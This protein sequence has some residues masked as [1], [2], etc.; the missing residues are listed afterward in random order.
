MRKSLGTLIAI[1]LILALLPSIPKALAV[2]DFRVLASPSS[3]TTTPG[4]VV[5]YLVE[6]DLL[7]PPSKEVQLLVSPWTLELE[8]FTFTWS[9]SSGFP[10]FSAILRVAVS[11]LKPPGTYTIPISGHNPE[12]GFRGKSVKL[13]VL[14]AVP[15]TDWE[16]SNPT[17]TPSAPKVG[18]SVTFKV[19]LRALGT[20][21]PYPQAVKIVAILD[22]TAISGGTIN[23]PGPTGL[24]MT[25]SSTPPW[26]AK[27]GAHTITWIVDPSP[28]GYD[29]P[30]RFN[31]EVSLPFTVE[32]II[33][34][35]DF[36]LSVIP[37]SRTIKAGESTTYSVEVSLEEG[38]AQPV[39]LSLSGFPSGVTYSFDPAESVPTF[40][41]T[42]EIGTLSNTPVGTY[43]LV[44]SAS[45][46]GK[47][48]KAEITLIVTSPIE[49]DFKI[50]VNPSTQTITPSQ[51]ITYFVDIEPIGGFDSSV[52]LAVSGLPAKASASFN[53]ASDVPAFSSKLTVVTDS[54]TPPG[55]YVLT[56]FASGGGKTHSITATL[57][58]QEI[59]APE[60][61]FDLLKLLLKENNLLLIV[62][63]VIIVI[64]LALLI[65]KRRRS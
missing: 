41:S 31:N 2:F 28:Y 39:S 42:L 25:V 47:V 50:S 30:N 18:D 20:T 55:T 24:M 1:F 65:R 17:L 40:I 26:K 32:P 59:K 46:G 3:R 48:K 38:E 22:G 23:Y 19:R 11:P 7:S 64:L 16:L 5:E 60:A 61:Q 6:V 49:K 58:I 29:D 53:P 9:V 12:V 62:L 54:S 14:P 57:I 13:T 51:S 21:S 33:K 52:E 27:E 56:I 36:S 35:F 8:G 15:T 34:P 44:I 4:G 43:E 10:P 45:G 37:D 63:G